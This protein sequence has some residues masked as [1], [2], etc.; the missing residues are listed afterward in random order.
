MFTLIAIGIGVAWLY[1]CVALFFPGW[2]PHTMAHHD[3][4]G[5]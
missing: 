3:K 4:P 5:L 1:S 2:F